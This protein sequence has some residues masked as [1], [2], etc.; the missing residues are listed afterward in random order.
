MAPKLKLDKHLVKQAVADAD[1]LIA[2]TALENASLGRS[3]TV[4]ANDTD[5][6]LMLVFHWKQD[7][8][9]ISVHSSVGSQGKKKLKVF[10][11]KEASEMLD[12][13]IKHLLLFVHAFGGCDTTSAIFDK[14]K[15]AVKKLLDKSVEAKTVAKE[16][17]NPNGMQKAI[18]KA[19]IQ[20]FVL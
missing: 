17:M 8:A 7:M 18:G 5:I 13:D 11:V 12:M 6:I 14:G 1:T 16:F 3:V 2:L 9:E 4:F 10:N 20:L 15:S 19:G